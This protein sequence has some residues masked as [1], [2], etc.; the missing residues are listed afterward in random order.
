MTGGI[1]RHHLRQIIIFERFL[2]FGYTGIHENMAGLHLICF[3]D[4]TLRPWFEGQKEV[5]RFGCTVS[6]A[7]SGHCIALLVDFELLKF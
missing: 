7:L 2:E 4:V 5:R 1:G 3:P 6:S